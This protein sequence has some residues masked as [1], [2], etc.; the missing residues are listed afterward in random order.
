MNNP[1]NNDHTRESFDWEKW[2]A[3]SKIT[4][5]PKSYFPDCSNDPFFKRKLERALEREAKYPDISRIKEKH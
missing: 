3:K 4:I 1:K 5:M 2:R